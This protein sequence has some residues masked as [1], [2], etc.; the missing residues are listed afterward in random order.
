MAI[1]ID[2]M[3]SYDLESITAELRRIAKKLGR[4]TLTWDDI[5]TYGRLNPITVKRKFGTMQ[6]AHLAAGL[7]PRV[8]RLTECANSQ[9]SREFVEDHREEVGEK[10][11]CQGIEKYGS[12]ATI[13]VVM[14]RFGSWNLALMAAATIAPASLAKGLYK[15]PLPKRQ[16]ISDR[17]RFLIFKR[18]RYKC[19]MCRTAGGVLEVDH[20]I[21]H[22]LGGSNK[23]DN[24][25]TLCRKCNRGKRDNLQ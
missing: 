9:S 19:K 8:S 17:R 24:L 6:K 14:D 2:F 18:D 20:V 4:Q 11:A 25:Q 15:V 23:L 7:V 3:Q 22:A 12:L 10:P 1:E 13:D 5:S 21:P 16:P